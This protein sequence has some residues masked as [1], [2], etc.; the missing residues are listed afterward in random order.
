MADEF[1]EYHH[2]EP[3]VGTNVTFSNSPFTIPLVKIIKGEKFIAAAKRDPFILIFRSPKLEHY[4]TEG[5]RECAF[6]NGP[7]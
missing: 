6:E 1:L 5:M 4:M 7:T 2:F 3:L